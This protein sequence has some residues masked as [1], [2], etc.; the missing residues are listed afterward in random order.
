MTLSRIPSSTEHVEFR[1][2]LP[3]P[4]GKAKY[5]PVTDSAPVQRWKGEKNPGRGV[6]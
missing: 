4:P 1:V 3:G 6:K 5:S 2:N